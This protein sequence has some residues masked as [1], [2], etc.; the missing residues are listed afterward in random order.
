MTSVFE[1][2]EMIRDTET[3]KGRPCDDRG[4]QCSDPSEGTARIA[5]SHQELE[6]RCGRDS[7]SEAPERM[8]RMAP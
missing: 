1:R 5:G 8:A 3:H 6:E 7:S 4:E 2:K